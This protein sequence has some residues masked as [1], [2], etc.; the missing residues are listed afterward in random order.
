MTMMKAAMLVKP[1]RFVLDEKPMPH[2]GPQDA[3]M[4]VTTTTIC[5]TDIHILKGR[6][7]G[8]AGP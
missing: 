2:V 1:G 4:R 6:V 7:P 8:G 5:G 3:P